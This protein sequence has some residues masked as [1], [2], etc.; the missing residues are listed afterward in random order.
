[1]GR[2]G[3]PN[4]VTNS[5]YDKDVTSQNDSGLGTGKT[6][7]EM[8]NPFTFIDAPASWDFA[9]VWGKSVAGENNGYMML[10]SLSIGLY[11]DYVRVG[12]ASRTYGDANSTITGAVLSGVGTGNVTVGWGSAIT[13]A[14]NAGDYAYSQPNVITLTDKNGG[15]VYSDLST[16]KLTINKAGL[17]V[18]ATGTQVYGSVTPSFGFSATGWKNGQSDTNLTGLA[19]S[20]TA[21]PTSNAGGIY[22]ASATGGV[23]GGA[24]AGNYTL[25]Y[26]AGAFSVTPALLTVTADNAS[27]RFGEANPPL[28]YRITAGGLVNGDQITGALTTAATQLSPA[29]TYAIEQGTVALS[30]NYRLTFVP[31]TLTVEASLD[32]LAGTVAS[33]VTRLR[34]RGRSCRRC[35]RFRAMR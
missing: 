11:D 10:R 1:M 12:D 14:T 6:T 31:G 27:R 34:T 3:N 28:T 25:A 30:A 7:V 2:V 15:T 20:T 29:G 21:T 18:V 26:Q 9:T 23:L 17:T 4:T 16:S 13:A 22:I 5:F 8:K 32:P 33:Q 19:F 24:A 35:R